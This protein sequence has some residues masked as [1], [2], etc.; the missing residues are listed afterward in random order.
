MASF[1]DQAREIGDARLAYRS[2]LQ[3][4]VAT[5]ELQARPAEVIQEVTLT[6]S[7]ADVE[8]ALSEIPLTRLTGG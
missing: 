1:I 6:L 2:R 4:E 8:T 7:M 5:D 3:I